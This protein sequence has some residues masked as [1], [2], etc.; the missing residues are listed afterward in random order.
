MVTVDLFE[1]KPFRVRVR[2]VLLKKIRFLDPIGIAL[3]G[4]RPVLQMGKQQR[5]DSVVVVDQ[6]SFGVSLRRKEHLVQVCKLQ[7]VSVYLQSRLFRGSSKQKLA[8][9]GRLLRRFTDFTG[10]PDRVFRIGCLRGAR[11]K[12]ARGGCLLVSS[13]KTSP[14]LQVPG[15]SRLCS[16][17]ERLAC[18][19]EVTSE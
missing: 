8:F 4:K 19:T 18:R 7:R 10:F 2:R 12:R 3:Q 1:T 16:G 15:E 11:E 6:V 14:A 17:R 13:S 5:G 9:S